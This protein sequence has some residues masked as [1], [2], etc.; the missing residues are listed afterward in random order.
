ML[1]LPTLATALPTPL[2]APL[3][4]LPPS[5]QVR[6]L[7]LLLLLLRTMMAIVPSDLLLPSLR[8][9]PQTPARTPRTDSSL[10][11]AV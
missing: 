9:R 11:W 2:P 5:L 1:R 7:L 8:P 6:L 3:L 10:L 4:S